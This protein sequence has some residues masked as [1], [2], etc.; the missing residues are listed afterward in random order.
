VAQRNEEL[1]VQRRKPKAKYELT[2]A[3]EATEV[4]DDG[5]AVHPPDSDTS[6]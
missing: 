5:F 4:K 6:R 1:V 2:K 3:A